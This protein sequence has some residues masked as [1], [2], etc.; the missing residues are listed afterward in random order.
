M[1]AAAAHAPANQDRISVE[2]MASLLPWNNYAR[3]NPTGA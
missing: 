3:M 1:I 2:F